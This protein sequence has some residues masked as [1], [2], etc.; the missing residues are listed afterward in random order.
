MTVYYAGCSA[1]ACRDPCYLPRDPVP[2]AGLGGDE[3]WGSSARSRRGTPASSTQRAIS[4]WSAASGSSRAARDHVAS[5]ELGQCSLVAVQGQQ[6]DGDLHILGISRRL[7]PESYVAGLMKLGH[8]Y[9]LDQLLPL[10]PLTMSSTRSTSRPNR[11]AAEITS[12]VA[13]RWAADGG[14]SA[15]SPRAPLRQARRA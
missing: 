1:W 13:R 11:R 12:Q 5:V 15:P 6:V 10:D 2:G 8:L 9:S 7:N 4:V 14:C 3:R